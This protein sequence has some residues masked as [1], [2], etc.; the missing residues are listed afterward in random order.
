[1]CQGL[2]CD[3]ALGYLWESPVDDRCVFQGVTCFFLSE[4]WLGCHYHNHS[5]ASWLLPDTSADPQEPPS[6]EDF[7]GS[8]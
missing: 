1:M 7:M 4:G 6:G 3:P 8:F 2:T 5:W